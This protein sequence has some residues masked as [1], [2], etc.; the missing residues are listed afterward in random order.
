MNTPPPSPP[1]AE[2]TTPTRPRRPTR[3]SWVLGV[4]SGA[5]Y[6]IAMRALPELPGA[7]AILHVMSV[8]F[9]VLVP[10]AMGYLAAI[11]PRTHVAAFVT[12]MLSIVVMYIVL[13]LIAWEGA[14]CLVMAVPIAWLMALLGALLTR[15]V[16]RGARR[17]TG[18]YLAIAPLILAPLEE[19]LPTPDDLR[20]VVNEVFI[21][22]DPAT[23]WTHI[24]DIPE[25]TSAEFEPRF[26]HWIGFLDRCPPA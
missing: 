26:V 4:V 8:T 20:D 5:T 9:L 7:L 13:A 21:A 12:P 24:A 17:K 23:V 11:G 6:G 3:A 18:T 19:Q 2:A 22:A 15:I 1:P 16:T 10:F 14:I 25:I